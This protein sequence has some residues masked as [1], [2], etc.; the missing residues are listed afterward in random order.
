MIFNEILRANIKNLHGFLPVYKPRG[1]NLQGLLHSLK[2]DINSVLV[3]NDIHHGTIKLGIA[4][5]LEPFASGLVTLVI[6]R[7]YLRRRNF[8]HA[9]YKYR[10]VVELG[11]E[12][13]HHCIDGKI[14]STC[15]I[16]DIPFQLIKRAAKS[17][18]GQHEQ[19]RCNIITNPYNA[20]YNAELSPDVRMLNDIEWPQPEYKHEQKYPIPPRYREV[21]CQSIQL[22]KYAK[23]YVILVVKCNGGLSIRQLVA[24]LAE[25]LGTKASVVEMVRLEEGPMSLDDIRPLQLYELNLEYY[26][27]RIASMKRLYES[28]IEKY[29]DM[30]EQEVNPTY[31]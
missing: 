12:R 26:I 15:N 25:K 29:D 28:H 9:D 7:G 30:F 3:N 1:V 23:P 24:K 22:V 6:G 5:A 2:A 27:Q 14:L 20:S 17:F 31:N 11:V 21:S 18:V 10:F 16:D 13:E 19:N 4:R 8:L